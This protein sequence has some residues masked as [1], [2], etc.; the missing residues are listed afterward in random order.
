MWQD[1]VVPSPE[2][3]QPYSVTNIEGPGRPL[4]PGGPMFPAAADV[5]FVDMRNEEVGVTLKLR[6]I[7]GRPALVGV[8]VGPILPTIVHEISATDIHSLPIDE[9]T[10]RAIFRAGGDFADSRTGAGHEDPSTEGTASV[11]TRR[12]HAMSDELLREVAEVVRAET[13][14]E[15]RQAVRRHFHTSERTASRW[16]AAARERGFI[17]DTSEGS[18]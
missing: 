1:D 15:P 6:V 12:R 11:R 8:V 9:L 14:G 16:I 5:T 4:Y 10:D 2:R 7:E 3:F 18:K 17:T 13:R